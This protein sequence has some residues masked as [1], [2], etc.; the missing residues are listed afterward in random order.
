M[1]VSL[2][3][4]SSGPRAAR[5]M[6]THLAQARRYGYLIAELIHAVSFS[7]HFGL[8]CVDAARLL[9]SLPAQG[10]VLRVR[11]VH[12][13]WSKLVH[14]QYVRERLPTISHE[15]QYVIQTRA[16]LIAA[17]T[18]MSAAENDEVN[19]SPQPSRCTPRTETSSW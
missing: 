9:A 6:G 11:L 19:A 14:V 13:P 8:D 3:I 7:C 18:F 10:K 2:Y 4:L 12:R 15:S 17:A 16:S 5:V 1:A